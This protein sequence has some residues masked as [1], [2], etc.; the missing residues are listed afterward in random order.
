MHPTPTGA[1]ITISSSRIRDRVSQPPELMVEANRG[2]SLNKSC[3]ISFSTRNSCSDSGTTSPLTV[4]R[5]GHGTDAKAP[6][7]SVSDPSDHLA[8]SDVDETCAGIVATAWCGRIRSHVCIRPE[9]TGLGRHRR[10]R[11]RWMPARE[12]HCGSKTDEAH[13]GKCNHCRDV[14]A[15]AQPGDEDGARDRRT[16]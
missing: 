13:D 8:S 9:P 10:V 5:S 2:S 3:S 12:E 11:L 4:A 6:L 7:E 16:K 14:P 15:M 1:A